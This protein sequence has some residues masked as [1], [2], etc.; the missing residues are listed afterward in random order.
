MQMKKRSF[1][2][3]LV[4]LTQIISCDVV[5]EDDGYYESYT[6]ETVYYYEEDEYDETDPSGGLDYWPEYDKG[7]FRDFHGSFVLDEYNS[8]CTHYGTGY[9]GLS[10]P[11]YLHTYIYGD[12]MDFETD[13]SNL[14]WNADINFDDSFVFETNYTNAYGHPSVILPCACVIDE[15]GSSHESI[16]CECNPS[17]SAWECSFFYDLI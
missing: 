17:N 15:E 12:M 2:L 9:P 5:W 4:L 16:A 14:V 8:T 11:S 6:T 1:C 10:L 7:S 3:L 13:H